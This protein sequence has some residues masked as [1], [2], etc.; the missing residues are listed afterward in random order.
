MCSFKVLNVAVVLIRWS[1]KIRRE[2]FKKPPRWKHNTMA[3]VSLRPHVD[4]EN[5]VPAGKST[6]SMFYLSDRLCPL[7]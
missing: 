7:C 1:R 6:K 2:K 4:A 3:F 5:F